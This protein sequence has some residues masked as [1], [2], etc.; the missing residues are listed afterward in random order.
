[1]TQKQKIIVGSAAIII[2]LAILSYILYIYVSLPPKQ[3]LIP[4]VAPPS[5]SPFP[6]PA[7]KS[8]PG[9]GGKIYDQSK[10]PIQNKVPTAPSP[11]VNPI[12]SVYKNPF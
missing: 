4:S 3:P 10:N 7:S 1:M 6:N 5:P 12:Q 8:N 11:T 2:F 9:L